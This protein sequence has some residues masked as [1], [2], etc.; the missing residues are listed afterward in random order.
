M[1]P[2]C[3]PQERK[4]IALLGRAPL[5]RIRSLPSCGR[6]NNISY[7]PVTGRGRA[8]LQTLEG[9]RVPTLVWICY[10][11]AQESELEILQEIGKMMRCR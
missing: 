8:R 11:S 4:P 2:T 7:L 5:V 10:S 6:V 1:E 3:A 9:P